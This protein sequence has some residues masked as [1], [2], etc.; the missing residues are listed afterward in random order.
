MIIFGELGEENCGRNVAYK[1]AGENGN[2]KSIFFKKS[3]EKFVHSVDSC[4]VSGKDEKEEK[5]S[6]KG[7]V[8]FIKSIPIH[9]E[10]HGRNN[11][12]TEPEGNDPENNKN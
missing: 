11:S 3:R 6:E 8:N 12:K 10:K 4:K 1:L 9:K 2:D 7:I 5:R